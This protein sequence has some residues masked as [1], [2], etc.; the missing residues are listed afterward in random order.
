MTFIAKEDPVLAK[1]LELGMRLWISRWFCEWGAKFP[2]WITTPLILDEDFTVTT[3]LT[4]V[5]FTRIQGFLKRDRV[6]GLTA[7]VGLTKPLS[8]YFFN[9]LP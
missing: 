2:I 9:K 5:P 6:T 7:F 8:T 1:P 3:A 4:N